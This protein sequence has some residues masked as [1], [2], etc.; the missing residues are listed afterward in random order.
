M[1]GGLAKAAWAHSQGSWAR[2]GAGEALSWVG[3]TRTI[4]VAIM[5]S[6][7]S[8]KLSMRW[9]C[10]VPSAASSS[11]VPAAESPCTQ[12]AG[13]GVPGLDMVGPGKQRRSECAR[14]SRGP[15]PLEGHHAKIKRTLCTSGKHPENG[16]EGTVPFTTASKYS[17]TDAAKEVRGAAEREYR[18][19]QKGTL[20]SRPGRPML[21]GTAS[22]LP[23]S[24]MGATGSL[25]KARIYIVLGRVC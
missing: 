17:G 9:E 22:V 5:D 7:A 18:P 20:C 1:L 19:E 24:S 11:C 4:T 23:S 6:R 3:P 12:R 25:S 8:L 10:W 13:S 21:V 14:C 16:C 15:A 2:G